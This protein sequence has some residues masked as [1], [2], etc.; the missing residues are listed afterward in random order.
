M[1]KDR[2]VRKNSTPEE[3]RKRIGK[4]HIDSGQVVLSDPCYLANEVC[5]PLVFGTGGDGTWS[6]VAVYRRYYSKIP[7]KQGGGTTYM[8]EIIRIELKRE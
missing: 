7:K 1:K 6:V 8:D 2:I 5:K 3:V 4:L